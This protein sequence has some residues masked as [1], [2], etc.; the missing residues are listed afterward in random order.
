MGAQDR[1]GGGLVPGLLLSRQ[2]FDA[3]FQEH[4]ALGQGQHDEV[5]I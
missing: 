1:E 3:F 2:K 4:I 5:G